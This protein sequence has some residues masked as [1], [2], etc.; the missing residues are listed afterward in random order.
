VAA[1]GYVAILLVA[2][3]IVLFASLITLFTLAIGFSTDSSTSPTVFDDVADVRLGNNLM[4]V[5]NNPRSRRRPRAT[6]F[7]ANN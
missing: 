2:L 5:D 1:L 6:V 4:R 3:A 7:T